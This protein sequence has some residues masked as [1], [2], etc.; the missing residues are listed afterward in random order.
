M[1]VVIRW[2]SDHEVW[3]DK[4]PQSRFQI[5]LQDDTKTIP[6]HFLFIDTVY[7]LPWWTWLMIQHVSKLYENHYCDVI[8]GAMASQITIIT[9]VYWAVYPGADQIKHQ[10]STSLAFVRG[11]HR[12]PVNS[13]HKWPVTRKMFPFNDVIMYCMFSSR[14]Q[15][16]FSLSDLNWINREHYFHVTKHSHS[17][18]KFCFTLIFSRSSDDISYGS[19]GR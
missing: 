14:S 16:A 9:I 15:A 11:I 2:W 17:H 13:L 6:L 4:L 1:N 8:I 5:Q 7:P 19:D 10:C 12:W 3:N 18:S